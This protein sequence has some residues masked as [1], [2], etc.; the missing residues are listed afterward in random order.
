MNEATERGLNTN[1]SFKGKR[2]VTVRE[3]SDSV[4][5]SEGE[6]K[7]IEKLDLSKNKRLETVRDL[8]LIGCYTGLRYSDYSILKPEQIKEGFIETTQIKT[9]DTIVI[10]VHTTV[11]R[12]IDQYN[13][14]LP[15]SITNQK[16]NQFLKE[17]AKKVEVLK[18]P[19]SVSFT[20]GG[21][22][23]SQTFEK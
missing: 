9:G 8:F 15:R 2:F 20:K 7:E 10:P 14:E 23:L 22:K 5:L 19:V 4:Y 17:L 11:K 3:N 13:G 18:K 12:I 6:I 16:T 21:L 1:L